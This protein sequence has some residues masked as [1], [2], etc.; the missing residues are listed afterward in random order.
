MQGNSFLKR[1]L[2]FLEKA[3][4]VGSCMKNENS[5]CYSFSEIILECA[6]LY[7]VREHR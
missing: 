2:H 4:N 7:N 5:S 3:Y 6:I 1:K